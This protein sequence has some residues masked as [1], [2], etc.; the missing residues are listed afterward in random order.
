MTEENGQPEHGEPGHD[1]APVVLDATGALAGII[2]RRDPDNPETIAVDSW[3]DGMSREAM[4]GILR[5]MADAWEAEAAE[6]GAI[7]RARTAGLN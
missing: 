2:F 4:A 1:C 5:Q 6:D 3:A 7:E